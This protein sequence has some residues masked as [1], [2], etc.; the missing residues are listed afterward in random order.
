MAN[1]PQM[2]AHYCL[3]DFDFYKNKFKINLQLLFNGY[4]IVMSEKITDVL[5][6]K[7]CSY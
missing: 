4:I 7:M 2:M 3:R 5:K 1:S 6:S